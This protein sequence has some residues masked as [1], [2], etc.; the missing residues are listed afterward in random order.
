MLVTLNILPNRVKE[1]CGILT[2]PRGSAILFKEVLEQGERQSSL[3]AL[4]EQ[5]IYRLTPAQALRVLKQR[6]DMV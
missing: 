3:D 4:E 6:S 1:A 2:L 5:N